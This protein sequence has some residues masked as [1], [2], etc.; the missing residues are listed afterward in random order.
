MDPE[1][2]FSSDDFFA[3][4]PIG[5]TLTLRLPDENTGL[6]FFAEAGPGLRLYSGE[7]SFAAVGHLG[8]GG[9]WKRVY[10][11]LSLDGLAEFKPCRNLD[12]GL[13]IRGGVVLGTWGK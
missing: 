2:L 1:L 11:R 12:M 13:G 3:F 6:H 4:F 10:L 7:V 8:L 5:G 9:W